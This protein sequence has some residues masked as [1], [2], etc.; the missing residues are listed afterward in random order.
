V[1]VFFCVCVNTDTVIKKE[2]NC[3]EASASG[4]FLSAL[5]LKGRGAAD[6]T[7]VSLRGPPASERCG[8]RADS[9]QEHACG[10]AR[11]PV[12]WK[13]SPFPTNKAGAQVG[14]GVTNLSP[15]ISID[16]KS[17]K[18]QI[19]VEIRERE[20]VSHPNPNLRVN[21]DV[22]QIRGRISLTHTIT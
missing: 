14:A 1:Q 12:E 9:A 5:K 21:S 18:K 15:V 6:G 7:R 11:H 20:G 2:I 8:R 10:V 22:N 16:D 4:F 3:Q 19:V 17:N 13:H